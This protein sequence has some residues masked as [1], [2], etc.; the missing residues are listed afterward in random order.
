MANDID[1]WMGVAHERAGNIDAAKKAYELATRANTGDLR[2]WAMA[3]WMLYKADRC[4]EA[5]SFLVNVARRGG[6]ADPK[7]QE[8]MAAC[9]SKRH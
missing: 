4:P 9:E 3:G 6:A 2:P 1:L 8:A 5:W 7:V